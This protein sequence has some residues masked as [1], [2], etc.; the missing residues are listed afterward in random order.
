ML[1]VTIKHSVQV[2]PAQGNGNRCL[3][4]C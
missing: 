3:K 2:V 4:L 1:F